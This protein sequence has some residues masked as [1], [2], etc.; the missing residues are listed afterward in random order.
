M[1]KAGRS[2]LLMFWLSWQAPNSF[3]VASKRCSHLPQLK[4]RLSLLKLLNYSRFK[5]GQW[6]QYCI[7]QPQHS[8]QMLVASQ[9]QLR[10]PSTRC[11]LLQ[12]TVQEDKTERWFLPTGAAAVSEHVCTDRCRQMGATL[13]TPGLA[14]TMPASAPHLENAHG[15]WQWFRAEAERYY[16][17]NYINCDNEGRLTEWSS[18]EG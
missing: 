13:P 7:W 2:L 14:R 3:Y 6:Q 4:L 17:V 15:C 12:P 10:D 5:Q 9:L 18:P 8:L 16:L 1:N 11:T